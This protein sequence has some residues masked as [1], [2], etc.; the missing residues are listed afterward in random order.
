MNNEALSEIMMWVFGFTAFF[1][2]AIHAA[3]KNIKKYRE[4]KKEDSG[5]GAFYASLFGLVA[6]IGFY[7]S[8]KSDNN[9]LKERFKKGQDIYCYESLTNAQWLKVNR[10]DGWYLEEDTLKHR[11]KGLKVGIFR[12]KESF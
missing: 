9:A 3:E 7:I 10:N 1:S 4:D 6:G 11:E 12:C 8:A 5:L 2:W